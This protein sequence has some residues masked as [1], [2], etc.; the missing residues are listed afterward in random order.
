MTMAEVQTAA[1]GSI[2][3][4]MLLSLSILALIGGIVGFYWYD[5]YALP[6]RVAMVVAGVAAGLGLAWL[7]SYGRQFW[8]FA[9][10]SRVELR[11]VVWPE[12]EDTIKTTYVVFIF[13]IIMGVFFWGL[14]WILT[15]LTRLLT[16]Q[17]G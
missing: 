9:M 10:G 6:L 5:E 11:K 2:K 1:N 7:S 4:S 14:D 3:D 17:S 16:G 8:Q 15:W 13:A 12:R